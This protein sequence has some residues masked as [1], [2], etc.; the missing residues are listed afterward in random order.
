VGWQSFN[1]V[2]PDKSKPPNTALIRVLRDV[3]HDHQDNMHWT[4]GT[5]RILDISLSEKRFPFLSLSLASRQ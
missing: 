2:R 3:P 5:H 4:A 1:R